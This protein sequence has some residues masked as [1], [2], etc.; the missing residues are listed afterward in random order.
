MREHDFDAGDVVSIRFGGVLRHYGVVTA[1]G[2]IISNSRLHDGV[3][4][5]TYE[6]FAA[7]RDVRLHGRYSSLDSYHVEL[8]ARRHLGKDYDLFG[9]NCGHFVRHAHR[10]KPTA[11]QVAAA[12]VRTFGDMLAGPKRRY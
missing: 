4:E 3:V 11:M 1:R 8:R 10:R 7:G 6:A 2:T 5:Q 12:T 9:S